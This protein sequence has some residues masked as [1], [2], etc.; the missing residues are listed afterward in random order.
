[1]VISAA[2]IPMA[3]LGSLRDINLS[4]PG[5]PLGTTIQDVSITGQGVLVHLVGQNVHFDG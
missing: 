4:L 1:M 5:L 3:V 2:G